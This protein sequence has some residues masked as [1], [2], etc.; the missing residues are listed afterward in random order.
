MDHSKPMHARPA[1]ARVPT[2]ENRAPTTPGRLFG[3]AKTLGVKS[4]PVTA[5]SSS[6]SS[7]YRP[8]PQKAVLVAPTSKPPADTQL[9]D[10]LSR[11]TLLETQL[12][13]SSEAESLLRAQLADAID[14]QETLA[15]ALAQ[16][17]ADL[18]DWQALA[19]DAVA[20]NDALRAKLVEMGVDPDT[21]VVHEAEPGEDATE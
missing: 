15:L 10:L 8:T 5:S 16:E 1:H 4:D 20:E 7:P 11:I 12:A 18:A 13:A 9:A 21:V 19:R 2:D 6:T 14:D 17:R 3:A